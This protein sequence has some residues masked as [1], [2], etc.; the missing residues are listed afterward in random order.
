VRALIL[1]LAVRGQQE[2][3]WFPIDSRVVDSYRDRIAEVDAADFIADALKLNQ[4][5][6]S[7]PLFLCLPELWQRV[8]ADDLLALLGRMEWGMTCFNYVEFVYVYL[9]VDL[10]AEA[11]Q[12]AGKP[13][14][15]A[16]LKLLL[17][18]SQAGRLFDRENL[19]H[20]LIYGHQAPYLRFDPGKWHDTTQ[21][22][23]RDLR[24]KPAL[25]GKQG[26]E[27]LTTLMAS[28]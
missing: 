20:E 22:L 15:M 9:E 10:L 27:Y 18:S 19:L 1:E 7:T 23:L 21:R 14:D 5:T 6:F 26:S 8:E 12:P 17:S 4:P 16:E 13:Y 3:D 28:T 25:T 2:A 11:L 24:L